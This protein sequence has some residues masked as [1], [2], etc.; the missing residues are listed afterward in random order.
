M[1]EKHIDKLNLELAEIKRLLILTL[2]EKPIKNTKI[3]EVLGISEGRLSQIMSPN[4]YK[5]GKNKNA[6]SG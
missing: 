6:K 2:Q 1:T 4:K 3:A 5:K